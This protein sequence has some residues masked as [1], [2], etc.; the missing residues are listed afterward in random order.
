M[1]QDLERARP[2]AAPASAEPLH[3]AGPSLAEMLLDAMD[4]PVMLLSAQL[5]VLV[6]NRAARQLALQG[7]GL[8]LHLGQLHMARPDDQRLL[9]RAVDAAIHRQLRGL[10]SLHPLDEQAETAAVLPMNTPD[11]GPAALLIWRRSQLCEALSLDAFVRDKGISPTEARV[12]QGLCEG[13]S[14]E[15]LARAHRV[16]LSTVRTQAGA[17]RAKTGVHD[18][19]TLI[20]QVAVLPPLV[21]VLGVGRG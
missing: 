20:R 2:G 17:L 3:R 21:P 8:H 19:R 10:V 6:D 7:A 18:L 4:Y 16:S 14:L 13:H 11:F 1:L 9:Q 12:L 5:R 15:G